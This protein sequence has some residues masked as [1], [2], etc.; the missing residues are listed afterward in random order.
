MTVPV[1]ATADECPEPPVLLA[2]AADVLEVRLPACTVTDDP[3]GMTVEPDKPPPPAVTLLDKLQFLPWHSCTDLS[4]RPVPTC[5]DDLSGPFAF[6][7]DAEE[8]LAASAQDCLG[9]R[10]VSGLAADDAIAGKIRA[11]QTLSVREKVKKTG[12]MVFCRVG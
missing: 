9:R 3:S 8:W 12:F 7:E 11:R 1:E 2:L 10:V 6:D 4:R 5:T